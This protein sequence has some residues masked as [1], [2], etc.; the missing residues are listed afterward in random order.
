MSILAILLTLA[1]PIGVC[2][3]VK[4]KLFCP[5]AKNSCP[6]FKLIE[7]WGADL[8]EWGAILVEVNF[9]HCL[10]NIRVLTIS[11]IVRGSL[12]IHAKHVK[13]GRNDTVN[14]LGTVHV[15]VV[16]CR[17]SDWQNK[18]ESNRCPHARSSPQS[19]A[20]STK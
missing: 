9:C 19:F 16:I 14:E 17:L 3:G 1:P 20:P 13:C 7:L 18:T 6:L 2:A 4:L 10:R 11:R 12:H 5:E 8:I 15:L